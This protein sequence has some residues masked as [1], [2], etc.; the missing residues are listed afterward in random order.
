MV[1]SYI[2]M[3]QKDFPPSANQACPGKREI[4]FR[5]PVL[6]A[7]TIYNRQRVVKHVNLRFYNV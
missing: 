3:E 6:Q 4:S 5:V 7:A 2:A 1:T